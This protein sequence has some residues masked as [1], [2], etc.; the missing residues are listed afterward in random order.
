MINA[1]PQA[2]AIICMEH[3]KLGHIVSTI[4]CSDNSHVGIVLLEGPQWILDRTL[5][6]AYNSELNKAYELLRCK[7]CSVTEHL[8]E[9]AVP[10]PSFKIRYRKGC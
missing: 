6:R 9:K 5:S 1:A 4:E 10:F 7:Q 2:E 8:P 3:V